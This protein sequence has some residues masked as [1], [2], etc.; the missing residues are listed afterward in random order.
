MDGDPSPVIEQARALVSLDEV[1]AVAQRLVRIRSENPPGDTREACAAIIDELEPAGFEVELFEPVAGFANVIAAWSFP[2]PGPTL[3]LNGHVDVV[4]V[5]DTAEAWTYDP[6]GAEL[7]G[8]KLYGRGSVD[9]KGQVAA[10]IVVARSIVRAGL[11]L[12]GRLV[13]TAVADEEQG[14]KRGTG[15][16]IEAGKIAGDAVLVAEGSDA[17]ITVAHRGLS[18]VQLTTHGRSA[19]AS[20]PENGVNAVEAMIEALRACRSLRLRHTPHPLLGSPSI[21]VGTTISGG[22]RPNVIPDLCRATLDVRN[23]PGMS[24]SAALADLEEHFRTCGL[25]EHQRPD[26]EFLVWGEAG[27]TSP[28]AEIVQVAARAYER[29][30]GRTP[31]LRGERAAS[32]GWWFTNRAGLPTVMA[33]GPGGV[34]AAHIVDECIDL[35]ELERYARV[36][37][38]IVARFLQP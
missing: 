9:M 28:D 1:V 25:P 7:H 23:L 35:G 3:V 24:E 30:F 8:G 33:L 21:A 17:G 14:G 12:R 10:L 29:E 34:A 13:L 27:E 19:H 37:A 2:E 38:D 36:Y 6:W 5:G 20:V 31:A 11:P 15:A 22:T 18:F 32:D 26:V 4:P 16:L